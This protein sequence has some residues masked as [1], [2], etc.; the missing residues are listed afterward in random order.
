MKEKIK[1][2]VK[3]YKLLLRSVPAW[4]VVAFVLSVILMNVL[5]T[6]AL[7]NEAW[8]AV[9]AGILLSWLTFLTMDCICRRF[10]AKA[11]NKLTVFAIICNLFFVL[12]F[13]GLLLIVTHVPYIA[14]LNGWFNLAPDGDGFL[15]VLAGNWKVLL[16]STLALIISAVAQNLLNRAV[17]KL[18]IKYELKDSFKKFAV[19]SYTS[20]FIG[21]WV[22]NLVFAIMAHLVFCIWGAPLS[23]VAC[24]IT[25]PLIGAIVEL[26]CEVIFSPLGYKIVKGWERDNVGVEYVEKHSAD[27][28]KLI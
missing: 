13:N 22:D 1:S 17:N 19:I 11:A 7:V 14:N 15:V 27:I 28:N 12:L 18:A 3:D 6:I 2:L 16:S 25:L 21:Q 10:G 20:T 9:D 24:L 8:I 5:A 4:I 26:L 23:L